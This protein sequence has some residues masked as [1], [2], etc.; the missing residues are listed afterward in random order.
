MG[1]LLKSAGVDSG[2]GKFEIFAGGS[3]IGKCF[4][5]HDLLGRLYRAIRA[6]RKW[7]ANYLYF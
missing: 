1:S 6:M 3:K 2:E 7:P 4:N 5:F